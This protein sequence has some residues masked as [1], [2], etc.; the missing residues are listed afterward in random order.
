MWEPTTIKV[1]FMI[2]AFLEAAILGVIPLKS[3][4]FRESPMI[5]GIANAFSGG[6]FLAIAFMHIMPEQTHTWECMQYVKSKCGEDTS[7]A[8]RL[9]IP[10]FLLVAGYTLILIIDKVLFDTHAILGHAEGEDG[11]G[12]HD[13]AGQEQTGNPTSLLRQSIAKV[14]RASVAGGGETDA[15][16]GAMSQ[17]QLE[18]A[19][20]KSLA[21]SLRKSDVFA[22][23]VSDARANRE[24]YKEA[25]EDALLSRK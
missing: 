11:E 8:S 19:V 18:Q 7:F 14:L 24:S 17:R 2:I 20:R 16:D 22:Q 12:H 1:A 13:H 4:R 5:L 10:F 25:N 9:N 3:A 6:V 21:S 15:A 23:R